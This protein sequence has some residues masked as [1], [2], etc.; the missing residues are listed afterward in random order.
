MHSLTSAS[1][2]LF[3]QVEEI[4]SVGTTHVIHCIIKFEKIILDMTAEAQ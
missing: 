4:A 3:D 1:M 2:D